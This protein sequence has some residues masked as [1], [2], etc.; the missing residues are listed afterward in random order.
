MRCGH[1]TSVHG[2]PS[3]EL[4]PHD[5]KS[6]ITEDFV[7]WCKLFSKESCFSERAGECGAVH[8]ST[9]FFI[10]D[11]AKALPIR[12]GSQTAWQA[13]RLDFIDNKKKMIAKEY[14]LQ[15]RCDFLC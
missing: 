10:M 1:E 2:R 4:T 12:I 9:Q 6:Q 14:E 7:S 5:W 8:F 11:K 3:W 13:I 15:G